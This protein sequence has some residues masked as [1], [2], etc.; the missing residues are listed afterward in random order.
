MKEVK[1]GNENFP[2]TNNM[3]VKNEY[4]VRLDVRKRLT[5]RNTNFE[6]FCMKVYDDGTITLEPRVLVSPQKVSKI[7]RK[8]KS[9]SIKQINKTETNNLTVETGC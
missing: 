6:Y 2:L 4:N 8:K 7:D 5:I 1:I 9:K 3:D